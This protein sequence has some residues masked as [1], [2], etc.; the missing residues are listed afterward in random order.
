MDSVISS[1]KASHFDG[2]GVAGPVAAPRVVFGWFLPDRF[3]LLGRLAYPLTVLSACFPNGNPTFHSLLFLSTL[4]L[5]SAFYTIIYFGLSVKGNL[6]FLKNWQDIVLAINDYNKL[7]NK[8][9]FYS[10]FKIRL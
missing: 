10:V 3:Q 7:Q 9:C 1:I 8:R 2:N 5:Y 4:S 6:C